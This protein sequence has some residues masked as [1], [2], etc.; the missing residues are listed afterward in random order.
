[1]LDPDGD[2]DGADAPALALEVSQFPSR[3]PFWLMLGMSARLAASSDPIMLFRLAS[4][5]VD[6]N[7]L[8]DA[9]GER[10]KFSPEKVG[11]RLRKLG[12]PTLRLSRLGNGLVMDKETLTRL[13]T[14]SSMYVGED[15]LAVAENLHCS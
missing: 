15:Q 13:L 11:H 9:R 10:S 5:T 4:P 1:M 7:R 12:L 6:V 14:L 3:V 8:V 2:G